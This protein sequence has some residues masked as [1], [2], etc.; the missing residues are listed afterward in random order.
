MSPA[1]SEKRKV[2]FIFRLVEWAFIPVTSR[3]LNGS[4]LLSLFL[5]LLL[6]LFQFGSHLLADAREAGL[7]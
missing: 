4:L 5:G 2:S 7:G 6:R 1:K 3:R